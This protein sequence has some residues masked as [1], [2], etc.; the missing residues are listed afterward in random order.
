MYTWVYLDKT[1]RL[2]QFPYPVLGLVIMRRISAPEH[3]YTYE[4]TEVCLRL[5]S[6]TGTA[7]DVIDGTRYETPF[8]HAVFKYPGSV[9]RYGVEG[10]DAFCFFYSPEVSERLR[11]RELLPEERIQPFRMTETIRELLRKLANLAATSREPASAD[12]IDLGCFALLEEL[13]FFR[14]G[15]REGEP[16][17]KHSVC[18][19]KALS[20]LQMNISRT[21][22]PDELAAVSGVSRRT[23]YRCWEEEC[24]VSPARYIREQIMERAKFLLTQTGMS[25]REVA[26]VLKFPDGQS[27]STVFRKHTGLTPG[28]YRKSRLPLPE[29]TVIPG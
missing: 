3:P 12:R 25:V 13:Q 4:N 21:L 19:G 28:E 7:E 24:S 23:F 11:E 14:E 10:R 5:E 16:E 22:T 27:F 15:V 29:R 26:S 8:P 1:K 17:N 20:Y 18:I 2:T 6:P 9:H